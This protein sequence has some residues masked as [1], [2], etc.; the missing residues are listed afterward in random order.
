[1][2]MQD[3]FSLQGKV[4][5]ITGAAQG[6]GREIAL[7]FAQ[8]GADIVA[9]DLSDE[10]LLT[11]KNAIE[12]KKRR[13]LV[14]TIDLAHGDQIERMVE[15]AVK[16][17]GRIDILANIAGVNVHKA[18]EE[19]TEKEWDF[20]LDINLKALFFC[21]QAVGKVMLRQGSGRII[22]MSSSFGVVGFGGRTAYAASKAAVSNLT[23]TLALEW[24]AKGIHVNALAPGPVWTEARHELF[25]NPEFYAN[26]VK[27]VPINRTAKPAEMVGPAIFLASEASSFVTGETLLVDGGFCAQ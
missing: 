3:L 26:L 12:A 24:S 4:A 20:V 21:C 15:T 5:L 10:K 27:K 2:T 22:N 13:C 6:I 23:K 1:M 25:S 14:L 8:Y 7:G 18:A 16:E 17:M 11:L 19:M 9:V